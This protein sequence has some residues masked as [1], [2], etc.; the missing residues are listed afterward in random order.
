M[1]EYQIII[2]YVEKV[3]CR[4]RV[5]KVAAA[6]M[7]YFMIYSCSVEKFWLCMTDGFY[8]KILFFSR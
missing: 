3:F 5:T 8:V 7:R 6:N 1:R 2:I 4:S